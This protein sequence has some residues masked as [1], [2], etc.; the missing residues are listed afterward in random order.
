LALDEVWD[1]GFIKGLESPITNHWPSGYCD[2]SFIWTDLSLTRH[3]H[4]Y[5]SVEGNQKGMVLMGKAMTTLRKPDLYDLFMLHAKARGESVD[6]EDQ[7]ETI[8]SVEH[9]VTPF[10]IERIMA[11]YVV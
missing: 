2:P 7:E 8:F 11:D 3:P 6:T 10:D 1:D 4:Y 9:G 5:N